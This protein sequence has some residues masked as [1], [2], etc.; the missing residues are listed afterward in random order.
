M[1]IKDG[2]KEKQNMNRSNQN[3]DKDLLES[4][5]GLTDEEKEEL[6][7]KT[8]EIVEKVDTESRTRTYSGIWKKVITIYSLIW[9]VFQLYFTTLGSM[10]A[11]TLRAYHATFL[12][13]YCFMLYPM[14]KSENRNRKFLPI[15]DIILITTTIF[16]FGYLIL[17]YQRIALTGGFLTDFEIALGIIAIILVFL[18][19]KRAAGGLVWVAAIFM[20][21]NFLGKYIPGSLG[22]AGFTLPRISGHMFWSSQ[23][24]LGAGI[25]VSATY[26]FV[27]VLFGAFLNHSGFTRFI[28]DV[29]LT[30]VGRQPGGPAKVATVVSGLMGMINGSAIANVAT[31]GTITIPL[32]ID[33]GYSK[34]FSGGVVAAAAT[35]GQFLPPVMGAVAFLM[36]EIVGVPYATVALAATVPA[37]LYYFVILMSVHFEAKRIGLKGLRKENIPAVLPIIKKDGHLLAPLITLLAIMFMG[38]TPLY[39]CVIS[40]FVTIIAC[41]LRKHTR[42]G[43]KTFIVAAEEGARGAIGV[44]VSCV[45]IGVIVGTVSLTGLGLK[46][47][48]LMLK[49]VGPGELVKCGIMVAIMSTI[50]GMGVPGIAAYVIITAVAVP[51]MVEV[52]AD[53]IPAH[54]FCLM[55]ASLS[56]ITP[57]VALSAYV[58][59]GI[60]GGDFVKT[61][62]CSCLVGLS[63]FIIPF[64]F[65]VNPILLIGQAPVGTGI[66]EIIIAIVGAT[67]GVFFLSAATQ[68]RY[69]RNNSIVESIIC[70]IIA[71]LMIDPSTTT[72]IVGLVIVAGLT[73][74]QLYMKRREKA[75]IA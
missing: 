28:N 26:I 22:H 20:A 9:V 40:I 54:L 17:N 11:I 70:L 21:Y 52:G 39:A 65:L 44:G 27:F 8:Q 66:L 45:A 32:M 6:E 19:A 57:P 31:T 10:D 33:N 25:G 41:N 55:Y 13:I 48:Y 47:G 3:N 67:I 16:T 35:G 69:L 62:L 14:T 42:M 4:M 53:L 50:L 29:S 1:D 12:M 56:N 63:G 51:V 36:A 71:I 37:V 15:I 18:A 5:T 68:R 61:G 43:L 2:K 30:L 73:S 24:L 7:R 59:S 64:F 34:D 38:Y 49:V 74:Y 60:A 72:D 75:S 58:S 46:F 23:G